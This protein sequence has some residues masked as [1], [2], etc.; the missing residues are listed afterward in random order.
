[1][2]PVEAIVQ[3]LRLA[4]RT[5]R[6]DARKIALADRLSALWKLKKTGVGEEATR[7]ADAIKDVERASQDFIAVDRALHASLNAA[8]PTMALLR[9]LIAGKLVGES[10]FAVRLSF[11]DRLVILTEVFGQLTR[12]AARGLDEPARL[13]LK[14]VR[15]GYVI[16]VAGVMREVYGRNLRAI[17]NRVLK[18]R[19]ETMELRRSNPA[20]EVIDSSLMGPV[21]LPT[22]FRQGERAIALG[23]D[24]IVGL[25]RREPR[26]EQLMLEDGTSV[27]VRI[28]GVLTVKVLAEIKG[29]TTAT[30]GL[31]QFVV[32]QRRGGQGY[33]QIGNEFWLLSPYRGDEV[34]HFLVAPAGEWMQRAAREA[35]EL[36][37]LGLSIEL[38]EIGAK[39]EDE[40]VDVARRLVDEIA[41]F[42]H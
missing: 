21:K 27:A 13:A 33:V 2:N 36:R 42:G 7:A 34:A 35:Q 10:A 6:A 19:L 30:D 11:N 16:G 39:E 1:M 40:I 17:A 15:G 38:A 28:E 5:S 20:L 18:L 22:R 24:R 41:D 12:T 9:A 32:M 3:A 23:P 29:R 25:G 31:R 26:I 14:S 8:E 37:G 4:A